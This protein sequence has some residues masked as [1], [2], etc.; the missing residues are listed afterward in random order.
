M[1]SAPAGQRSFHRFER[2]GLNRHRRLA[3]HGHVPVGVQINLSENFAIIPEYSFVN[4]LEGSNG[5]NEIVLTDWTD[6]TIGAPDRIDNFDEDDVIH[7][8]LDDVV[9]PV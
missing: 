6:S 2:V 7:K 3:N 5:E 4:S 9:I 8:D 1:S